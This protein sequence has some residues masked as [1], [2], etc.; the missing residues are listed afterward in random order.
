[1]SIP[2]THSKHWWD[3]R[4]PLGPLPH[5]LYSVCRRQ[6]HTAQPRL[7]FHWSCGTWCHQLHLPPVWDFI[8][9]PSLFIVMSVAQ[10]LFR[11]SEPFKHEAPKDEWAFIRD[12]VLLTQW[13]PAVLSAVWNFQP[14][15]PNLWLRGQDQW[16]LAMGSS[17]LGPE[18]AGRLQAFLRGASSLLWHS[19]VEGEM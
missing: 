4:P 13:E 3:C 11:R 10:F 18:R 1:M 17:L 2:P 12:S 6:L 5:P 15:F 8:D 19:G 16:S 7:A 14:D 9:M